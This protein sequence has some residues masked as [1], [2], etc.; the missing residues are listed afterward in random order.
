M[1]ALLRF[2]MKSNSSALLFFCI[3]VFSFQSFAENN[4]QFERM[5]PNL[6]QPWYFQDLQSVVQTNDF[7]YAFEDKGTRVDNRYNFYKL[8]KSGHLVSKF[9]GTFDSGQCSYLPGM[10]TGSLGSKKAVNFKMFHLNSKIYAV[11]WRIGC[12]IDEQPQTGLAVFDQDFKFSDFYPIEIDRRNISL[13]D[14]V[15][16]TLV[17][18]EDTI[19]YRQY[20][21]FG[22]LLSETE[23]LLLSNYYSPSEVNDTIGGNGRHVFYDNKVYFLSNRASAID[24]KCVLAF[25]LSLQE[26]EPLIIDG[27]SCADA[28]MSGIAIDDDNLVLHLINKGVEASSFANYSSVIKYSF[29]DETI[30]FDNAY[31]DSHQTSLAV[32]REF[33]D[34]QASDEIIF[35]TGTE[36][37]R[38]AS[39]GNLLTR[40]STD[41]GNSN[42]FTNPYQRIAVNDANNKF[43]TIKYLSANVDLKVF[44]DVGNSLLDLAIDLS[45]LSE[46]LPWQGFINIIGADFDENDNILIFYKSGVFEFDTAGNFV[47]VTQ[48]ITDTETTKAVFDVEVD[49]GT[50]YLLGNDFSGEVP[51]IIEIKPDGVTNV[52]TIPNALEGYTA[53]NSWGSSI[54]IDGGHLYTIVEQF[55]SPIISDYLFDL[56]IAT[57]EIS[58]RP[59]PNPID[60][61]FKPHNKS[62]DIESGK[63]FVDSARSALFNVYNLADFSFSHFLQGRNSADKV[64]SSNSENSDIRIVGDTIYL[65]DGPYRRMQK[66]K[67]VDT[68]SNAK[69]IIIAGGGPYAGNSLWNATLM[70][71]NFAYST[72][73][74]QGYTKE[75]I[76]YFA[77]ANFDLDGNG[78][79]D[80]F[81]GFPT[82]DNIQLSLE[83]WG[84]D[85]DNVVVYMVDHG[86]VDNFRLSETSTLEVNE[87]DGWLSTLESNM[88]G[89]LTVVYDACKSGSFVDELQGEGRTIVTSSDEQENAYFLSQGAIS[90]SSFFWQNNFN[91]QSIGESFSNARETILANTDA[92]QTPQ[93]SVN[94]VLLGEDLSSVSSQY[95]GNG[96]QYVQ[97]APVITSVSE[98]QNI[99]DTTS[100]GLQASGISDGDGVARVWGIVWPPN[101]TPPEGVAPVLDLP[102]FDF[103]KILGTNNYEATFDGFTQAGEYRIA[104]FARDTLG[105]TSPSKLTTVTVDSALSRKAIVIGGGELGDGS[106]TEVEQLTQQAYAA[107]VRQG[108]DDE[109]IYFIAPTAASEGIDG[110]NTLSNVEYGLTTWATEQSSDVFVY[111]V[112]PSSAGSDLR[113]SGDD[114]S[115]TDDEWLLKADLV[116]WITQLQ[117]Q[118]S[119]T[120]TLL[121]DMSNSGQLVSSLS[122]DSAVERIVMSSTGEDEGAFWLTSAFP[123]FSKYFW[124]QVTS[125]SSIRDA[126]LYGKR[127]VDFT[128]FKQAPLLDDNHNGTGNEKAD[129]RYARTHWIGVGI[130]TAGDEPVFTEY[131]GSGSEGVV[132]L[133]G[134]DEL[135]LS[136]SDIVSTSVITDVSAHIYGPDGE[137]RSYELMSVDTNSF[138]LEVD[139]FRFAG[140][141]QVMFEAQNADGY[142][143]TPVSIVV[144]RTRGVD[145][146]DGYEPDNTPDT[147]NVLAVDS[148]LVNAHSLHE[149]GDVDW[150][151]LYANKNADGTIGLELN[152]SNVGVGIDPQVELYAAD[153]VTLLKSADDGVEGEGEI[154][155]LDVNE[156]GLY[157]LKVFISPLAENVFDSANSGYEIALG[158]T[159]AGFPGR[160]VGRVVDALTGNGLSRVSISTSIG[161]GALTLPSGLFQLSHANG[162]HTITFAL[163]GYQEVS[164]TINVEEL[165]TVNISPVMT[166]AGNSNTAPVFTG[167]PVTGV[168]EKRLYRYEVGVSDVDADPLTLRLQSGPAWLQLSA[169]VLSGTPQQ[170]Q[171]GS[172]EV[173]LSVSDGQSTTEQRFTVTVSNVNDAPVFTSMAPTEGV[174]GT[175]YRY[176]LASSDEDGDNVVYT[177]QNLPDWLSLNDGVLSGTPGEGDAGDYSIALTVTD[178]TSSSSQIIELTVSARLSITAPADITLEATGLMTEVDLGVAQV[179][180]EGRAVSVSDAGPFA[181]GEHVLTWSVLGSDDTPLTDTQ[182]VTITDTTAPVLTAPAEVVVNGQGLLTDVSS[183]LSLTGVDVVEGEIA[184][185]IV[186]EVSLSPGRHDVTWQVMDSRAN[187]AQTIQ[188]VV[189]LPIATLAGEYQGRAGEVLTLPVVLNGDAADYPVTFEVQVSG[190]ASAASYQ[191]V[192]PVVTITSGRE[193]SFDIRFDTDGIVDGA[194]LELSLV[195][196][197]NATIAAEVVARVTLEDIPAILLSGELMLLPDISGDGVQELGDY[198]LDTALAQ[199]RLEVLDGKSQ[200]TLRTITWADNYLDSS[201]SLHV[202]SDM[203]DNGAAEVGVFGLQDGLNNEN[204]PQMFIRDLET[205]NRVSVLNWPANWSEVSALVLPDMSGD[206]IVDVGIQGRFK[207]GSRPQLVVRDGVS[208]AS[209]NTYGYPNLFSAP[210]FYVHSDVDNDG[211][212]EISTFGRISRTNKVQI[213]VADGLS[214]S[215]R[216]KAYNF[217]D[218]WD[219][220]SWHRLDDS[221]G[222]G[223]DDWGMF[224]INKDDGRPQLINK[225]G[226]DPRGALR[227]FA[228]P[229]ALQDASLFLIPDMNN[230]GVDEVAVGGRRTNG[231]YQFQVQDGT[232]RN[233]VLANH[234]V[235]LRLENL[236]YQVLPDLSGDGQ[237]EIGFIGINESGEYELVIREGDTVNGEYGRRNLGNDWST[238]PKVTSLGDTD[239]DG[240]PDLLIYG[241]NSTTQQMKLKAL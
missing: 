45:A 168:A 189:V 199:V 98:S 35:T 109:S 30:V 161:D 180:I 42:G 32:N 79:L 150:Y 169:G 218:K 197:T 192:E 214:P 87:L 213:K 186:S 59:L 19:F 65:W 1:T 92:P 17:T 219:N 63:L 88:E 85:A 117:G 119:G 144:Q 21:E 3:F 22:E 145:E 66:L 11:Y 133:T 202:L 232:N 40:W 239:G 160:I 172:H 74:S 25:D 16:S 132:E 20:D 149:Q 234:N 147:A 57:G 93:I 146:G 96:T 12:N 167:T 159:G 46:D 154:L 170:A 106:N 112:G 10:W 179:S 137:S 97:E 140:S 2:N 134:S 108:Y 86:G 84:A 177:A 182:R 6:S 226:T 67:R 188:S 113:L 101:Y 9:E 127:A 31:F 58:Q 217:P 53:R 75:R 80:D 27:F 198:T 196:A 183:V 128:L 136:V 94:G 48:I 26:V 228:W 191:I 155:S 54:R 157:Y 166:L 18:E 49:Q 28:Y 221:N 5:W 36:I 176:T 240:V 193:G 124:S 143:A 73:Q 229:S 163:E 91:G 60:L 241:Q 203:N 122:S 162:E 153:G 14:G 104:V 171:V 70:N 100:A 76:R 29:T 209:V 78:E 212:A 184:A 33:N 178:G 227:I 23:S 211:Y 156:A 114:S 175:E 152:L 103:S 95:I 8:N 62:F 72:L 201:I 15:F 165:Q 13:T 185:S 141:Y 71:A 61:N 52:I 4:Y 123:S 210:V 34:I 56:N 164:E 64:N 174:Q 216:L 230:D 200:S 125:G 118:I 194:T 126:F 238:T 148:A 116:A 43:L 233:S 151:V 81:A 37:V 142:F 7:V 111:L 121:A 224:G 190:T 237:A 44:D 129:G 38:L 187:Q 77:E 24:G 181:V 51:H 105:N 68:L 107:L 39:N 204:K 130:L 225:D 110:L 223:I 115:A 120:V 236:R 235:N 173:V 82:K 89:G 138:A 207:E 222:D 83:E 50:V 231:R 47:S 206:G 69:A 41:G 102:T 135:L 220:V 55:G 215:N 205:G 90:F 158:S 208:N 99:S 131:T 139:D 195:S